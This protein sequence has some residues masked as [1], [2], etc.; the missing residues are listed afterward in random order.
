MGYS[1]WGHKELDMTERLT[2][3]HTHTHNTHTH[4]YTGLKIEI[5]DVMCLEIPMC[6]TNQS[7][8]VSQAEGL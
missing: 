7:F 1:S 6:T 4:I 8:S 5:R 3:T 2:H